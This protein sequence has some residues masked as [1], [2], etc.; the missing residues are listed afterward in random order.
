MNGV[1]AVPMITL[2]EFVNVKHLTL[3]KIDV[4]GFEKFVLEGAR[5][6]LEHTDYI[7]FEAWDQ[8]Y[9]KHGY[10]FRDVYDLLRS[11]QF[12]VAKFD[13]ADYF[14]DVHK[15]AEFSVCTNLLAYRD[16]EVLKKRSTSGLQLR[17]R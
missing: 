3:L 1:I 11:K 16:K 9:K 13:P 7:Y 5:H 8:H 6:L 17:D 12:E 14:I 4:E 15:D 10:S 2:D